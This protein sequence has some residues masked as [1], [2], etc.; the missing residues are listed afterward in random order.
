MN[1]LLLAPSKKV[2]I[3]RIL[4]DWFYVVAMNAIIE[5]TCAKKIW[6]NPFKFSEPI[7]KDKTRG[8]A[9]TLSNGKSLDLHFI[10]KRNVSFANKKGT[11]PRATWRSTIV[12]H[13]LRNP[14]SNQK[15]FF[16]RQQLTSGLFVGKDG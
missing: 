16:N 2:A 7:C 10:I 12:G 9:M 15:G 1:E 13:L 8:E 6:K 14:T 3:E 4:R 11:N 5:N